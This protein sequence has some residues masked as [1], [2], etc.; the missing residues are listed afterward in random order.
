MD[1]VNILTLTPWKYANYNRYGTTQL[2]E[3]LG[4]LRL[5]TLTVNVIDEMLSSH[6]EKYRLFTFQ[7]HKSNFVSEWLLFT[8]TSQYDQNSE[9]AQYCHQE[10]IFFLLKKYKHRSLITKIFVGDFPGLFQL[11]IFMIPPIHSCA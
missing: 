9:C 10:N 4:I 3:T 2:K 11:N 5:E 1:R 7:I 6:L 8:L